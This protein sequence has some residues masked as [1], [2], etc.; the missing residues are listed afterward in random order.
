MAV[1]NGYDKRVR[2]TKL[3]LREALLDLMKEK[4]VGKITPTE[5]CRRAEI[6][7]NTFY[8]HYQS[9]EELLASIEDEFFDKV[10]GAFTADAKE[11]A[12]SE[13]IEEICKAIYENEDIC[14]VLLSRNG[15]VEFLYHIIATAHDQTVAEWRARGLKLKEDDI[16]LIYTYNTNGCVAVVREWLNTG[17]KKS[18][19]EIAGLLAQIISNGLNSFMDVKKSI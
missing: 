19:K 8:A 17:M 4:P 6:N 9:P 1:K 11:Y 18:P 15:D 12:L 14:T 2:Y 10:K 16:E 5:L 7:R 3:F 13:Q